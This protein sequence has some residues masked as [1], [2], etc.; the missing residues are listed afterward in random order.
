MVTRKQH[1]PTT[2]ASDMYRLA[3]LHHNG[4]VY[5]DVSTYLEDDMSWIENIARMPSHYFGNRFGKLPEV[6]LTFH[7]SEASPGT[8]EVDP[9]H[10][11]KYYWH[12][13]Y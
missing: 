11:T 6:V 2:T 10:N 8:W 3:L 5:I 4:G 13:G 12:I 7:P 1:Y 9:E